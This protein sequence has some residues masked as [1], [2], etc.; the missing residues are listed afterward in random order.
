MW[1]RHGRQHKCMEEKSTWTY[2]MKESSHY[3]SPDFTRPPPDFIQPFQ[4]QQQP[5]ASSFQPSMWSWAEAPTEP[6]WDSARAGWQNGAAAGVGFSSHRGN[7]GP[8][9]P[10]GKLCRHRYSNITLCSYQWHHPVDL[11]MLQILFLNAIYMYY[12]CNC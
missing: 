7:Y 11:Q 6:G 9:R 10:Y 4:Q 1:D 2:E 8:R 12:K 5:R 3:P